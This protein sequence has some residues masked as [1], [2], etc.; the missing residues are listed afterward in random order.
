MMAGWNASE[1]SLSQLHR[2]FEQADE[3]F[4]LEGSWQPEGSTM[5]A[6]SFGWKE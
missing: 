4:V 3:R 5:T 6:V 1:R 2:L